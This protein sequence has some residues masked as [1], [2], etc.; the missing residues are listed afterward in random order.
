MSVI[1][2]DG[3]NRGIDE[4]FDPAQGQVEGIDGA[5][6]PLHQIDRHQAADAQLTACM[7]EAHLLPIRAVEVGIFFQFAR[8]NVVRRAVNIQIQ[9]DKMLE[10]L[11]VADG[12]SQICQVGAVG[13]GRQ[14]LGEFADGSGIVVCFNMFPG[15]GN[16]HT[17]QNLKE[18]KVQH[19]QEVFCGTLFR[20]PFA[21]GVECFL[22]IPE[23]LINGT[24]GF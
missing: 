22:S 4:L 8:K 2:V 21:P 24:G 7:V 13:L 6:H 1:V 14:P 23:D 9:V 20:F 10:D 16:G 17:V 11:V 12:T 15:S 5:F 19:G 3:G 18:V